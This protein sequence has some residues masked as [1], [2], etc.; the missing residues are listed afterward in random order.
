MSAVFRTIR[1]RG[2]VNAVSPLTRPNNT[3]AYIAKDT[4]ADLATGAHVWKWAGLLGASQLAGSS[5]KIVRAVLLTDQV[6]NTEVFRL[7]LY[8]AAPTALGDNVPC[9]APLLADVATYLGPVDFP[10][11]VGEATSSAAHAVSVV[12]HQIASDANGDIYGILE[13]VGGFTPAANQK[14]EITLFAQAGAGA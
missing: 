13:A 11:A 8:S 12:E 9:T 6:T 1:K 4:V 14:W 2:T 5:G 10:A 3:D 7:H